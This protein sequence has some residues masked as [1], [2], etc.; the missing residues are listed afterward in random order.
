MN[1]ILVLITLIICLFTDLKY[2]KIYN[3]V[4][5]PTLLLGIILN[6]YGHG[7]MG[8]VKSGQ[9]FMLGLGLLFLPFM[10]G[11]IGAGDVKLLAIVGAIKGPVF[12][13]YSFIGMGIAG[14]VISV[15]ILLCQR[16]LLK[17][18][19]NIIKGFLI[20]FTTS[21]KVA[22]F[23]TDEQKNN[24]PYGIAIVIGVLGTYLVR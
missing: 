16:R 23:G 18:M 9:G 4:L 24:F 5:I 6:I 19:I 14:G 10:W 22:T 21:F 20:L 2:R 3:K 12:V 13:F 8:L 15:V 1:D 17:S 11:G 7:L